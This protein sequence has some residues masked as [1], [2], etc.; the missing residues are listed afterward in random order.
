MLCLPSADGQRRRVV[1]QVVW[2]DRI[3]R[4]EASDGQ[5]ADLRMSIL[6]YDPKTRNG[7]H[8]LSAPYGWVPDLP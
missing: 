1:Q 4:P 6:S 8:S 5:R 7:A 2:G 3:A